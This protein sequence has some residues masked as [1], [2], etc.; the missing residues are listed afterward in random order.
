MSRDQ[1]IVFFKF[2]QDEA[3][4]KQWP[5]NQEIFNTYQESFNIISIISD[6][7]VFR[8]S[9]TAIYIHKSSQVST[10]FSKMTFTYYE[11]SD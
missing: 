7:F 2:Y 9:I 1:E 4:Y 10:V 11:L 3:R 8:P 5:T 6:R